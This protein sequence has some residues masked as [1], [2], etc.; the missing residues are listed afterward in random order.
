MSRRTL[1]NFLVSVMVQMLPLLIERITPMLR[2]Q[3]VSFVNSFAEQAEQSPNPYDDI[4]ADLLKTLFSLE[5]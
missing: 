3:I 5:D 2:E 1:S 4:L